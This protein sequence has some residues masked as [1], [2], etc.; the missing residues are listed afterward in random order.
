MCVD[1]YVCDVKNTH[2]DKLYKL[3]I[4]IPKFLDPKKVVFNFSDYVLSEREEF[5]LSLGLDFCLPNFKPS[6]SQFFLSFELLFNRLRN[7]RIS[8]DLKNF[9]GELRHFAQKAFLNLKSGWLPFF[10][11]EDYKLLKADVIEF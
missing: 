2:Q 6:Y 5:L 9:E 4:T 11:K 10:S 1:S 3:G 7:L 8:P